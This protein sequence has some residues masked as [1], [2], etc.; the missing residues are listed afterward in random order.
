M[1]GCKLL[2]TVAAFGALYCVLGSNA[3]LLGDEWET[4][5]PYYEDDAWYD[6]SEWFDGND[7]NPTDESVGVW[8]D[9]TYDF[10]S[11]TGADRDNDRGDSLYGNYDYTDEDDYEYDNTY[12]GGYGFDSDADY[13]Y[14]DHDEYQTDGIYGYDGIQRSDNWFYDYYDD[15]YNYYS[16]VDGDGLYD[17]NYRYFDFDSDG[18]Y[19]AYSVYS[20]QD[21]DGLFDDYNYYSLNDLGNTNDSQKKARDQWSEEG[22]EQR[23]KG[24]IVQLKKVSVRDT[25]NL[26]A[27]IEQDGQQKCYADLGPA[28]SLDAFDLSEGDQ[29]SVRGPVT[30]VGGKKLLVAKQLQANKKS[31]RIDRSNRRFAGVIDGL[32]TIDSRGQEHQLFKLRSDSGKRFL[33]DAGP[34]NKLGVELSQGDTVNVRGPVARINDRTVVLAQTLT[35]D[36]DE[37]EIDRRPRQSSNSNRQT[38]AN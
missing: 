38:R 10:S 3:L 11:E 5:T 29:I 18:Y 7:Y 37:I 14:D 12:N 27:Q 23:I 6:V 25:K 8:D 30:K 2:S 9:E 20:D 28:N 33:I 36:G 1:T 34:A 35:L 21:G 32:S 15:G 31:T 26:L 22:K 13:L 16:D 17:Y 24:E 4:H 19:D